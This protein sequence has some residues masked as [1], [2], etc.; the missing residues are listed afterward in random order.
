MD[1]SWSCGRVSVASAFPNLNTKSSVRHMNI[2]ISN[3]PSSKFKYEMIWNSWS[4]VL[5][6]KKINRWCSMKKIVYVV[7]LSKDL[8]KEA[9]KF[10]R[11]RFWSCKDVTIVWSWSEVDNCLL[12]ITT[13][14][15]K[16]RLQK[17]AD[18]LLHFRKLFSYVWMVTSTSF[19]CND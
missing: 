16:H 1:F 15:C 12:W 8:S 17:F 18:F 19:F 2:D 7:S 5:Q 9:E 10:H 6:T 3:K 11:E 4:K 13:E 14:I